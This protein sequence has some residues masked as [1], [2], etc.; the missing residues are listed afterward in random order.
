VR[1]LVVSD[2][3]PPVA[4]GG[5]E[6]ECAGVVAHL[7]GEH[8]VLVLTSDRRRDELPAEAGV[9]RALPYLGGNRVREVLRSPLAAARAAATT[10]RAV[11]AFRPELAFVWESIMIPQS[12][13]AVLA[14]AGVPIAYRVCVAWASRVFYGDRFMRE[15]ATQGAG[16]RRPWSWAMRG[17]NRL[18]GMQLDATTAHPAAVSWVSDALREASPLSP[19]VHPVLERTIWPA[20]EQADR[21]AGQARTPSPEPSIAFL[22]RVEP[23]KGVDVVRS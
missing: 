10:R 13:I 4:F 16:L 12:V 11:A 9:R 8:D 1:I 17:F 20:T 5:Y 21:Y 22:G 15:L 18:P 2:L 23:A 19:V 3:F 7:R 6:R 14:E